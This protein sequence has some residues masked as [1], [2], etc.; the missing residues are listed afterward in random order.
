[1][2]H[3]NIFL[4]VLPACF[5]TFKSL[6]LLTSRLYLKHLQNQEEEEEDDD[7]EGGGAV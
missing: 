3:R 7:D 4:N 1:M 5:C 6:K 2:L